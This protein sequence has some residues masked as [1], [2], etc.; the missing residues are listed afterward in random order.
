MLH[1]LITTASALENAEVEAAAWVGVAIRIVV[2]RAAI[3][4]GPVV[5]ATIVVVVTVSI[6]GVV[7]MVTVSVFLFHQLGVGGIAAIDQRLRPARGTIEL[8]RTIVAR[9]RLR[10]DCGRGEHRAQGN[11]WQFHGSRGLGFCKL[12]RAPSP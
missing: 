7:I 12:R 4:I 10:R 11:Y 2:V 9:I 6:S 8:R 1:Q 3:V 5:R